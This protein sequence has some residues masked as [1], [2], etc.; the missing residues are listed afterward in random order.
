MNSFSNNNIITIDL[1]THEVH[2]PL[3]LLLAPQV[4]PSSSSSSSTT[5][6]TFSTVTRV[7]GWNQS[8]NSRD[9]SGGISGGRSGGRSGGG[10]GGTNHQ[11]SSVSS[12]VLGPIQRSGRV[13]IG[14]RLVSINGISVQERT[15]ENIMSLLHSLVNASIS[16]C[17]GSGGGGGATSSKL[18]SLG[19]QAYIKE[20]I[21]GGTTTTTTETLLPKRRIWNLTHN[22]Y[23]YSFSSSLEGIQMRQKEIVLDQQTQQP[24]PQQE[25]DAKRILERYA[26]YEIKCHLILRP[27][28]S[29]TSS[30]S[31]TISTSIEE[32]RQPEDSTTTPSDHIYSWSIWKRY[33]EFASLHSKLLVEYEWQL[34]SL[35]SLVIFPS[36]KHVRSWWAK[37]ASMENT[38]TT[39]TTT[40]NTSTTGS[41]SGSTTSSTF[42]SKAEEAFIQQRQTELK[43]YWNQL[44]PCTSLFDFGNP[45]SHR[46]AIFMAEFLKVNQYW[47]SSSSTVTTTRKEHQHQQ[48]HQ[49]V[50]T[51]AAA[52]YQH[53]LNSIDEEEEEEGKGDVGIQS[54]DMSMISQLSYPSISQEVVLD[55]MMEDEKELKV[56]GNIIVPSS[57]NTRTSTA[58]SRSNPPTPGSTT[59]STNSSKRTPTRRPRRKNQAAFQRRLAMDSL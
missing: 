38:S 46:Y 36:A 33:S 57:P 49:P 54:S 31:T 24:Q 30:S 26:E 9:T 39:T 32:Q 2:T 15:F 44:Q 8:S 45:E 25:G 14:D 16:G 3:G 51:A 6:H 42:G 52:L 22:R 11:S 41:T 1:S 23:L 37:A 28:S 43:N 50:G 58:G 19:F 27:P 34:K 55:A 56:N 48:H 21:G 53:E 12:S 40:S 10:N 59:T 5:Q 29:T 17:G 13:R 7:V 18:T 20:E 47:H 35:H 4:H